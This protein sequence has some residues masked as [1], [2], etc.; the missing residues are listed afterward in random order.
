M[1]SGVDNARALAEN[2]I[3]Q[4]YQVTV[5]TDA[6]WELRKRRRRGDI[7]MTVVIQAVSP[8]PSVPPADSPWGPPTGPPR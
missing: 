5:A 4:G 1:A 8:A 6:A 7:V 2:L 3:N